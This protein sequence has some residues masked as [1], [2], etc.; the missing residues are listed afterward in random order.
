MSTI[1]DQPFNRIAFDNQW[2]HD[3]GEEIYDPEA[4]EQEYDNSDPVQLHEDPLCLA[5]CAALRGDTVA[6]K[7]MADAVNASRPVKCN[8]ATPGF[9]EVA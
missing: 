2:G 1:P 3:E 6:L 7:T 9:G 4:D 8:P 5:L